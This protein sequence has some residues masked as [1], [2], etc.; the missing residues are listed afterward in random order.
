MN[1]KGSELKQAEQALQLGF[2]VQAGICAPSSFQTRGGY[3]RSF[4]CSSESCARVFRGSERAEYQAIGQRD[5]LVSITV[6]LDTRVTN[7]GLVI[8]TTSG[9]VI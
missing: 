3:R 2:L 9:P 7:S 1:P 5:A 6:A 4:R 8:S